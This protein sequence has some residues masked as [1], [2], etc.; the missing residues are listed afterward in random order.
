M[1][2]TRTKR[3]MADRSF[4][5]LAILV[6]LALSLAITLALLF[7]RQVMERNRAMIEFHVFRVMTGI[8][9]E[10][11]GSAHFDASLWPGLDGF[12]VYGE[13]GAPLMRYGTAPERLSDT[14]KIPF[15]GISDLS[16][17]SMTILRRTG[18]GP[19]ADYP[20]LPDSDRRGFRR[21]MGLMMGFARHGSDS[22]KPRMGMMRGNGLKAK[23]L[24]SAPALPSGFIKGF[25]FI[26]YGVAGMLRDARLALVFVAC[27]L[28]AF[29]S[30]VTLLVMYSRRLV[31]YRERERDTAQLVQLGE[32]A[33]T[34]AHEIKNP[35]G[36]IRVQCATLRRTLPDERVRNIS[37][38]EE[39]TARL[40]H[41]TDRL[42]DFLSSSTG[43]PAYRDP[44]SF[45]AE[46]ARRYGESVAV[47]PYEGPVSSVFIDPARMLQVLDNLIANARESIAA[48]REEENLPGAVSPALPE[49]S[50]TLRRGVATF[51]IADRG[52][53]ISEDQKGRVFEPFFTTK[54]RGTGI[55]LALSRRFMEQAGGTLSFAARQ[56]G[57]CVFSASLPLVKGD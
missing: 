55:G 5:I 44:A 53:G 57:G 49:L 47:A 17:S 28:A 24:P 42:R 45:L 43:N 21:D 35:L 1:R 50:L 23:G 34:L 33:R 2:E 46:C 20:S 10:Y 54:A 30:I 13:D 41:L 22:D 52:V 6:V 9:D 56:G 7:V 36:V 16:G 19:G 29:F 48:A 12:A 26:D 14:G 8:L 4:R 11:S 3:I 27:F 32:A 25:V 51:A 31:A 40:A 37:V 38:I 18:G 15:P 39:E